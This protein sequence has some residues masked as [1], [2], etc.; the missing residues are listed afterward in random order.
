MNDKNNGAGQEEI[1]MIKNKHSSGGG[2]KHTKS[3]SLV[4]VE[5]VALV[6]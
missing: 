5:V 3:T 1:I 2:G 4:Q 6:V